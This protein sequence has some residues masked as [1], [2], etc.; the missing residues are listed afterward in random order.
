MES[1]RHGTYVVLRKTS[2]NPGTIICQRRTSL[3]TVIPFVGEVDGLDGPVCVGNKA[4][5]R[6]PPRRSEE[7]TGEGCHPQISGVREIRGE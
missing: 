7:R 6:T 1:R 4:D 5:Q 3:L 2:T